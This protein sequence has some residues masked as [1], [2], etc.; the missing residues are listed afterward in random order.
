MAARVSTFILACLATIIALPFTQVS[1]EFCS[2]WYDHSLSTPFLLGAIVGAFIGFIVW[3][4]LTIIF[5]LEHEFTHFL[6]ALF[7]LRKPIRIVAGHH[8]GEVIYAGRGSTIIALAPYFLPTFTLFLLGIQPLVQAQ[9]QR[10]TVLIIGVTWGY[11]LLTGLIES[12]PKQLDLRRGPHPILYRCLLDKL[13][14]VYGDRDFS[15]ARLVESI[16]LV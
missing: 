11:H 5:V 16:G 9:F 12:H 8:D 1:S 4:Y 10:Q 14:D 2:L 6:T 7:L 3:K 13:Y 15:G